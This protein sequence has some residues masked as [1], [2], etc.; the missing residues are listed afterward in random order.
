[1]H[2][3]YSGQVQGVGLR[4]TIQEVALELRIYGWVK[5]LADRR[6]EVLAEA[7]E[8]DLGIFLAK[9]N[10]KFSQYIQAVD[11][12]WQPAAGELRDFQV[13]F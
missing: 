3:Y 12:D 7:E 2:L 5:N 8:A 13:L 1:M 6:V 9:I 11:I 4:Y 10:E